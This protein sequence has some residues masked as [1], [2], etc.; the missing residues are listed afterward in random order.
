[1]SKVAI[2]C[3][4]LA[5]ALTGCLSDDQSLKLNAEKYVSAMLKDPESAQF[6]ELY[7]VPG[8][9]QEGMQDVA[10]CGLVNAKNSF[11][12]YGGNERF[13]AY[14]Y[15]GT[16]GGS[17]LLGISRAYLE[18]ADRRST[19]GTM[20]APNKATIFE[21]IHWNKACADETHPPT[22]SGEDHQN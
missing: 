10:I 2:L 8:A 20:D 18:G 3:V 7:L 4:V 19:V 21:E 13:V 12:A 6:T 16:V 1:M 14:G 15:K 9:V 22:Y 5:T 17:K 11:G